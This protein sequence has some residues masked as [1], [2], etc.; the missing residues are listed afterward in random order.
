MADQEAAPHPAAP[1]PAVPETHVAAKPTSEACRAAY[2]AFASKHHASFAHV[3]SDGTEF[4]AIKPASSGIC[5][6]FALI[7]TVCKAASDADIIR[8]S[9]WTTKGY[10]GKKQLSNRGR[11]LVSL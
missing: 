10:R 9:V 4:M 3:R 8:R 2:D 5:E 11:N 1:H 7:C 6:E